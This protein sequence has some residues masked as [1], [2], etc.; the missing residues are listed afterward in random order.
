MAI[1]I[2]AEARTETNPRKLRREGFVPAVVYG[3]NTHE[4]IQ[5]NTRDLQKALGKATR[6]SH[7]EVSVG[8]KSYDAFLRE[9][10]YHPISESVL[11]VDFYQPGK[12][13]MVSLNVPVR[14]V[15]TPVGLKLGGNLF[16]IREFIPMRGAMESIPEIIELDVTNMD[17][18]SVLRLGDIQAEGVSL[19]LPL[20]STIATVKLPRRVVEPV[21]EGEVAEGAEGA[22][23]AAEG[24]EGDA[25]KP[26]EGDED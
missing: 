3:N 6:S 25:E 7:F 10:Q 9:V 11:H 24:A 1:A 17:V 20:D 2:S 5:I 12:G 16:Q 15:G 14:L 22:E 26:D 21:E 4:K 23:G 18:G 13:K 19:L 8:G